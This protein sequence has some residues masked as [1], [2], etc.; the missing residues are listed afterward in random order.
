MSNGNTNCPHNSLDLEHLAYGLM[1]L[2]K[3]G[4][5]RRKCVCFVAV[6]VCSGKCPLPSPPLPVQPPGGLKGAGGQGGHFGVEMAKL[7]TVT[8]Q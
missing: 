3:I 1:T 2:S 8:H 5:Q 6:A 4:D 7:R